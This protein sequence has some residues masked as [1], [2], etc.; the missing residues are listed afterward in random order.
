MSCVCVKAERRMGKHGLAQNQSIR[1]SE[2]ESQGQWAC[3]MG[4]LRR[5]NV[6]YTGLKK[7]IQARDIDNVRHGGVKVRRWCYTVL[8]EEVRYRYPVEPGKKSPRGP[9][10]A[11]PVRARRSTPHSPVFVSGTSWVIGPG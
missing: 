8:N 2:V 3:A 9:S 6:G 4:V 1:L 5:G 11:A 7:A 10:L